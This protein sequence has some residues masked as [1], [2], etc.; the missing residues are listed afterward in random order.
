ME[1]MW[2]G[3]SCFRLRDR[4]VCVVTDPFDSSLGFALPRL[5][6]DIVTVSHDHPHHGYVPA[7]TDDAKVIDSPGEYEIRSVF[8]TGIATY[9]TRPQVAGEDVKA[10]RNLIFVFE[11]DGLTVCHLGDLAHVPPQE[12][13]QALNMVDVLIV[14]VGGGMNSLNAAKAAEIVSLVEPNLVI[15]MHYQTGTLPL[16][17]DGVDRFLKEMGVARVEPVGV[18]KVSETSLP[19]E[20]QVVVLTPKGA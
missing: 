9:P 17:L 15:P 13:V 2:F 16:D 5:Q 6:A 18:L 3:H 14:P 19:Q 4:D 12:Q 7:V 10:Q 1:I 8:I 20:T 11:F